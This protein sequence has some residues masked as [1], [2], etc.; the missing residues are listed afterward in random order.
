MLHPG[1]RPVGVATRG[2]PEYSDAH[3]FVPAMPR[4]NMKTDQQLKRDV[5]EELSWDPR[6]TDSEIGVAAKDGVVTLSGSVKSYAQRLAAEH[7][8]ERVSGVRAIAEELHVKL[9]GTIEL[10]DTDIG[11]R[12]VNAMKW[13]VEVPD[14]KIKLRVEHGWITLEGDVDW[15]F[16]RQAT[17]R[18]VRY[19]TGVKGVTNKIRIAPHVSAYDVSARIKEA[20]RRSADTESAKI[21]VES[22]GG[23]VTLRGN[24]HSWAERADAERAAWGAPGV[25]TV[26]D[27]LTVA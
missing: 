22:E 6:I 18:A 15:Q 7:A 24:V 16:E 20:L 14:S 8:A 19:L 3:S 21:E 23:R 27:R 4:G 9:P 25:T 17:E 12:A 26:D 13:D 1:C 2:N 5:E 11:H 10:S